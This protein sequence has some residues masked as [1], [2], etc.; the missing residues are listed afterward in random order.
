MKCESGV[1]SYWQTSL[2][3]SGA[4][5]SAGKRRARNR[6]AASTPAGATSRDA[7]VGSMG[8]AG[9]QVAG[10]ALP[11]HRAHAGEVD[12]REPRR[13]IA[14]SQLVETEA[15]RRESDRRRAA[16]TVVVAEHPQDAGGTHQSGGFGAVLAPQAKR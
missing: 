10:V 9:E 3:T 15:L 14:C 6:R 4:S 13:G 8:T 2:A 16:D 1:D 12:L 7:V 11:E 5:A